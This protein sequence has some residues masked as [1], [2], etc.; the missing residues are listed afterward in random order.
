MLRARLRPMDFRERR[1]NLIGKAYVLAIL[2]L[3]T[4]P[5]FAQAAVGGPKKNQNYIGG[6]VA[7]KNPV[8]PS[9]R[10]DVVRTGQTAARPPKH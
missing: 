2:H 9:R 7:P 8:V 5:C 6:L 1:K 10:G 4:A 3:W